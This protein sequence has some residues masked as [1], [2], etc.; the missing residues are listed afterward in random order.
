MKTFIN[1]LS[2]TRNHFIDSVHK[3]MSNGCP[4][5]ICGA[6]YIAQITW[7]FMQKRGLSADYVAVDEQYLTQDIHFYGLPVTSFET[8]THSGKQ[9]NY[10]IA[11]QHFSDVLREKLA[12]SSR[13]MLFYDCAFIGVN[14]PEIFTYEW[15][16]A[17]DA[18]LNDFYTS[19]EDVRSQ[20]TLLAYLN[21]RICAREGYYA[22][23]L[24]T[25]HYFPQELITLGENEVFVDCGAFNG[26]SI[27]GFMRALA[28]NDAGPPERIFAFEPD[29][30]TFALLQK[31]TSSL[32]QCLCLPN[33]VWHEKTSMY[34]NASNSLSSSIDDESGA[35]KVDL[36]TID[37]V[38]AGHDVSFIKMDIEGAELAALKGA[39]K[40]I[41][42]HQPI[43]AI[44]LYH[45]P[46]DLITIPQFI[47]ELHRDYR[48]W[49]RAHHPRFA[50]EMVLYAIPPT[51]VVA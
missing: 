22:Q 13:E 47:H 29:T 17:N 23:Q 41:T 18:V 5:V 49:L 11:M 19:L 50:Y 9:Y 4:I 38:T 10:I 2:E 7:E 35:L 44:S 16:K 26:D 42:A 14:S 24:H 45:K 32:P 30:E 37:E 21:Q 48:F 31:N 3:M 51:K 6:G 1:L 46:E 27:D 12:Q 28:R 15:C 25:Q 34:F 43:L 39:Q 8:L 40:T 36:L 20:E 33:G